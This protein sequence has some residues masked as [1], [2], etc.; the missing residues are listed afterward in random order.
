[1]NRRLFL[2]L[3]LST[4]AAPVVARLPTSQARILRLHHLHTNERLNLTYRIGDCYQRS[5][6]N[7]LNLFLRDFRTGESTIIDPKLFDL[8]YDMQTMLHHQESVC[9]IIGGYRSPKTNAMLRKTSSGVA[10]HSLHMHGQALDIRITD[11]P[12][13]AIRDAALRLARG[14]VGYYPKSDFVHID[15]GQVRRWGA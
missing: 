1:M 11:T 13:S 6:L 3:A 5:A 12:T 15:T 10:K 7:R 9:E 2:G 8:L 14:G 4:I